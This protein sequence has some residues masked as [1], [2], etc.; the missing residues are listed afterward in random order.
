M[1][2]LRFGSSIPGSYWGCCA[3]CIAQNFNFD[4]DEK[5]S[6]E[7]VDGDGG[8][9][10]VKN[11]E[12]MF[13]GKT[14][15]EIFESRLRIATF[16]STDKPNHVF[17]AVLTAEQLSYGRGIKWLKILKEAGFEFIRTT[18]NSVYSGSQVISTPGQPTSSPHE[19]YLF[20]LFRNIGNGY[21]KDPYTPPKQWTDL[22]S[23]VPEAWRAIE[24]Y[25]NDGVEPAE[26]NL[27]VQAKQLELWNASE[28]AKMY[29]EAEL[30]ADG[31]PVWMAGRRS[32]KPQQLKSERKADTTTTAVSASSPFGKSAP[33]PEPTHNID[34]DVDDDECCGWGEDC[35]C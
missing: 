25:V 20:G 35:D 18:D 4:P 16:N 19:N 33:P 29:T 34:Y 17:L 27:L 24:Y 5:A 26:L 30:V 2:F 9:P 1:E 21:V 6:I 12:T 31:V 13:L 3:V 22:P 7:L 15:R 32:T 11:G 23:V 10:M 8:N 14:Y 28:P